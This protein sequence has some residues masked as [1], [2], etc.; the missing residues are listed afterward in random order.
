MRSMLRTR[1]ARPL[2]TMLHLVVTPS[3]SSHF[4][5]PEPIRSKKMPTGGNQQLYSPVLLPTTFAGYC[6]PDH[7]SHHSASLAWRSPSGSRVLDFHSQVRITKLRIPKRLTYLW[8][9]CRDSKVP[10]SA[11][12]YRTGFT[13]LDR[14]YRLKNAMSRNALRN[15][16]VVLYCPCIL[17]FRPKLLFLRI[18]S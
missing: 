8:T 6:N 12:Q 5:V 7:A 16:S 4:W 2:F 9:R 13:F 14:D 11:I 17:S 3:Q 10:V 1:E 15:S 18:R